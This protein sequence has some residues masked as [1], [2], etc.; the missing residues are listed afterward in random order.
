MAM[1]HFVVAAMC[2]VLL[3]SSEAWAALNDRGGGLIYDTDLNVTWLQNANYAQT[4]GYDADGKMTWYEAN[5]WAANLTYYDSVRNVTY[6]DWRLPTTTDLGESGCIFAKSGSDCG[7]NVDPASSE[8]AHLYFTEL[9]NT[10]VYD[11]ITGQIRGGGVIG[12]DTGLVNKGPF[13]NF[14]SYIYWSG[15]EFAPNADSAIGWVFTTDIGYQY[16]YE[17]SLGCYAL[18]VRPGDVAAVPELE[19]W[20]LMLSGLTLVG[21]MARTRKHAKS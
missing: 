5:T 12:V 2:G 7:F 20:G 21:A 11:A 13:T 3:V 10:S 14:Q 9:G 18:A 6:D 19:A 17:N 16:Y 4:I 15:T 1:K 8:M